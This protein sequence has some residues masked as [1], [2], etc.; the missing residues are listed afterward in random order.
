LKDE[1]RKSWVSL[2]S[3]QPTHWTLPAMSQSDFAEHF[4][5]A[6]DPAFYLAPLV[7]FA[8]IQE[9]RLKTSRFPPILLALI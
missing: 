5:F 8:L 2:R 4:P 6:L 9:K 1:L 7:W 3:T